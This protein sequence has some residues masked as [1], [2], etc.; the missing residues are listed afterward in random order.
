MEETIRERCLIRD[1][2]TNDTI[3]PAFCLPQCKLFLQR[4]KGEVASYSYREK[5]VRLK[6]NTS[7]CQTRLFLFLCTTIT[8]QST[9]K[10]ILPF[11]MG[12]NVYN[13][14]TYIFVHFCTSI[15]N[16]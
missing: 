11:T 4:K 16:R 8:H 10:T 12:R 2:N 9:C 6:Q 1:E 15:F 7:R 13:H 5:K 3:L 14:L